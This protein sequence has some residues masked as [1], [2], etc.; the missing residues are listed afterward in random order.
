ML[1]TLTALYP[2]KMYHVYA[3]KCITRYHLVQIQIHFNYKPGMVGFG[4][5]GGQKELS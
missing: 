3:K 4:N 1:T 2:L 5:H